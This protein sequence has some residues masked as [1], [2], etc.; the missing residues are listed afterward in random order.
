M[1]SL[2]KM[3]KVTIF[4]LVA[5]LIFSQYT[6]AQSCAVD[7]AIDQKIATS[8]AAKVSAALARAQLVCINISSRGRLA[9]CP[10]GYKTTSCSCGMACGSWDIRNENICHCQCAVMDWASARCCKVSI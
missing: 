3:M 9:V 10:S 7:N 2:H 4:L 5:M 8:V 6:R 1:D